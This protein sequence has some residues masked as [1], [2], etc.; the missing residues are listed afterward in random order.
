MDY[1]LEQAVNGP[2]GSHPLLDGTMKAVAGG[3]EAAF[4][5]AVV[6]WYAYGWLRRSRAD[7]FGAVAAVAAALLALGVNQVVGHVV[8]RPRPFRTHPGVHV[9]LS[10]SADSSFPRDHAAAAFAIAVVAVAVRPRLGW[11]LLVAALMVAYARVYVGA[12]YPGDVGGGAVV[13]AVVAALV[14]R[15]LKVVPRRLTDAADA[16][17]RGLHVPRAASPRSSPN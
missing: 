12:H 8:A 9:L 13:G 7:Q 2:A 5:L 1:A 17:L 4:L 16:L 15:P 10:R 3:A 14:L 6:V 11:V